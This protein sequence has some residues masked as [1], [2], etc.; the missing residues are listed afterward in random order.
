M[1]FDF[2]VSN[3][4]FSGALHLKLHRVLSSLASDSG[5]VVF[6]HPANS[7]LVHKVMNSDGHTKIMDYSGLE[8][9]KMF[10][11]NHIFDI[12]LFV[13]VGITVWSKSK[14]SGAKVHVVDNAFTGTEYFCDHDKIHVHGARF[15]E[16]LKW[17]EDNVA[18]PLGNLREHG[19][20]QAKDDYYI[21]LSILRG[22]A[23]KVDDSTRPDDDYFTLLPRDESATIEQCSVSKSRGYDNIFSFH[24]KQE[25]QNFI[26]Y[27]KTKCV[28]F[29]LS[30]SKSN[31][32]MFRG[33][34]ARIPWMDFSTGYSDEFLR[35][36]WNVGDDLWN[37]ID[38]YIPD[39][40]IDY[41]YSKT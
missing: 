3:P 14:P 12:Y 36:V 30:L 18:F 29:L 24:T 31:P 34:M 1:T 41:S 6:V 20:R 25:R 8:Y 22:H 27:L 37:Y 17:F 28:R 23:P 32:M 15:P 39:Y 10:W 2:I 38:G 26:S 7:M 5:K 33:E 35:K 11:A 9:V 16:F 4:P 21:K 19:S 40:Y 13:P